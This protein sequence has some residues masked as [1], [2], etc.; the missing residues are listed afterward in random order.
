MKEWKEEEDFPWSEIT[1]EDIR[2]IWQ[3]QREHPYDPSCRPREWIQFPRSEMTDDD[4]NRVGQWRR[5]QTIAEEQEEES[6]K[7][8]QE[9]QR[10]RKVYSAYCKE[11]TCFHYVQA[12]SLFC[13]D[14]QHKNRTV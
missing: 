11:P 13:I 7:H 6:R 2:R 14:H 4:W 10:E 12:S 8:K 3:W 5:A 1:Q 9:Q